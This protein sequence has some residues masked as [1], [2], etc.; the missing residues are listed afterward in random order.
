PPIRPRRRLRPGFGG[1]LR[2]LGRQ[3]IDGPMWRAVANFVIACAFGGLIIRAF[4]SLVSSGFMAFAP[5]YST[6]VVD[7][8]FGIRIDAGWGT[9]AGILGVLASAAAIVGMA[10]LHRIISLALVVPSREEE[11]IEQVHMSSAQR[12]GAVR[13]ADVERTRIE[14]DLHDGV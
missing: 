6:G 8:P 5:L 1:W 11:L 13:A 9:V 12:D 3:F 14:R 7:G 2:S 4:W 10:V